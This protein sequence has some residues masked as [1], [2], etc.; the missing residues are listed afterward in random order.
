MET[1]MTILFVLS[2]VLIIL[3]GAAVVSVLA[4][5]YDSKNVE[6]TEIWVILVSVA[7][8]LG[9]YIASVNIDDYQA[10]MK[11]EQFKSVCVLNSGDDRFDA[12]S[13]NAIFKFD[14]DIEVEV[15]GGEWVVRLDDEVYD[16]AKLPSCKKK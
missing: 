9:G 11:L 6:S 15:T 1:F 14:G 2:V 10:G 5:M 3:A 13:G 4:I 12:T 8:G 7:V 16:A